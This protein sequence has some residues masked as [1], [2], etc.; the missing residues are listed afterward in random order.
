MFIASMCSQVFNVLC[1]VQ[2]A[3]KYTYCLWFL[4]VLS[5]LYHHWFFLLN[6]TLRE[7]GGKV[8]SFQ[9]V[10]IHMT[11]ILGSFMVVTMLLILNFNTYN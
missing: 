5:P 9:R 4:S 11:K 8:E 1:I 3:C 7:F 2:R 6:T 10:I